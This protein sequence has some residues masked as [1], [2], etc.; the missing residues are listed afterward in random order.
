MSKIWR[1]NTICFGLLFSTPFTR[2]FLWSFHERWKEF[3][4]PCLAIRSWSIWIVVLHL[5]MY[6]G[7]CCENLARQVIS[8]VQWGGRRYVYISVSGLPSA[9]HYLLSDDEWVSEPSST[10]RA[11]VTMQ[12]Y[13]SMW[14]RNVE[15][16]KCELEQNIML[17]IRNICTMSL[18]IVN[19]CLVVDCCWAPIM[20]L[21]E[22]CI[23]LNSPKINWYW[24]IY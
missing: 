21:F 16:G 9:T 4:V 3:S 24:T 15:D 6:N 17:R 11:T 23:V 19:N 13:S 1:R 14:Y 5:P 20:V 18:T 8:H 10:L 2:S 12:S 22:N 7:A